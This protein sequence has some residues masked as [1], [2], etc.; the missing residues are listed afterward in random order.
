MNGDGTGDDT[1]WLG[2]GEGFL[3]IDRDGN[4]RIESAA[5]LSFLTEKEDAATALEGLAVLDSNKDGKINASDA[6]FGEL[7]VWVDGNGNGVTDAGE[8]ETLAQHGIVSINLSA[9]AANEIHKIGENALLATSTFTRSNG[10]VATLGSVMLAYRPSAVRIPSSMMSGLLAEKLR[11]RR[12]FLGLSVD[13]VATLS[14]E[15]EPNTG[16]QVTQ[17]LAPRPDLSAGYLAPDSGNVDS[18]LA[19]SAALPLSA[20]KIAAKLALLRQTMMGDA[21]PLTDAAPSGSVESADL[22]P[23]L[24]A[25]SMAAFGVRSGEGEW[26]DRSARDVARFDYFAA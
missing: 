2:K 14:D 18:A 23:L 6:R 26:K 24:M 16:T 8:L 19:D 1:G 22:R 9:R 21:L 17:N 4:G 13:D 7:R 15:N 11:I 12:E 3:V 5:E 10:S 20:P 25:Q